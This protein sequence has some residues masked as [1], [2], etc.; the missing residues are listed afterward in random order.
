MNLS[1]VSARLYECGA[2]IAALRSARALSNDFDKVNYYFEEASFEGPTK[3]CFPQVKISSASRKRNSASTPLGIYTRKMQTDCAD[4]VIVHNFDHPHSVV[5]DLAEKRPLLWMMHDASPVTGLHYSMKSLNGEKIIQYVSKKGIPDRSFFERTASMKMGFAAPSNWLEKIAKY[6]VNSGTPTFLIRNTVPTDLFQPRDKLIARTIV[7]ARPDAFVILF[8]AGRGALERKNLL[9]LMDALTMISDPALQ[10]LIVGGLPSSDIKID[11]RCLFLPNFE[12]QRDPIRASHLYCA[13]DL[14]LLSSLIDNLPN[15][16]LESYFC[17]TPVLSSRA[18]GSPEMMIENETGW[19]FNPNS[20]ADLATKIIELMSIRSLEKFGK[21]GLS[22]VQENFSEDG[23]REAYRNALEHVGNLEHGRA[24]VKQYKPNALPEKPD[25]PIYT[26]D[27]APISFNDALALHRGHNPDSHTAVYRDKWNPSFAERS[28]ISLS[29]R[30]ASSGHPIR[31]NEERI[32]RWRNAYRGK[33]AFL[34]GNGP[35][36]NRCDLSYLRDEITIGVNSIFMK[37]DELNGLP[38]H[39]VVEDFFVAEDR[40]HQI[41]DLKN[42]NK[43]FGNYL[44]YCLEGEDVNWLNVRM[45]YD[46]YKEFPYFSP[47]AVRQVWAG[48]SVTFICMQLAFFF[49]VK[50]L[51]LIGFDHH[52]V[53]PETTDIDGNDLTSLG[54]DPNHFDKT[55]FGKGLRWHDPK[56]DR[57]ELGYKKAGHYFGK[58][59][60]KIYNATVGGRLEVFER[61]NY[62]D[63]FGPSS[64]RDQ[65]SMPLSLITT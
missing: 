5:C 1:V 38:T 64:V 21:R 51:Y 40:A 61:V 27:P 57:M 26:P 19:L 6:Y 39:Y 12:Q 49:G 22:F 30:M 55:Y 53:I 43:W 2:S 58:H 48:G 9:V 29:A 50:E 56:T 41:N 45:R 10:V 46:N 32:L 18:G 34:I 37:E 8:F 14:F 23:V 24:I 11:D 52:Y 36:L 15:T 63:I 17:G 35:S 47:D 3:Q 59:G 13:S 16:I 31:S 33:R 28:W 54:D 65:E 4:V 20:P 60:R 25:A 44:S 62:S 7:G 42:T